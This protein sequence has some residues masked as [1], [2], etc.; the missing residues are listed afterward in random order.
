M[1]MRRSLILGAIAA[2]GLM[3][4]AVQFGVANEP[5]LKHIHTPTAEVGTD[6]VRQASDGDCGGPHHPCPE[7]SPQ[8]CGGP[9]HPCEEEPPHDCGGPHQEPCDGSGDGHG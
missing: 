7:E 5:P 2:L 8:H 1:V 4:G 9:H 6:S 3:L